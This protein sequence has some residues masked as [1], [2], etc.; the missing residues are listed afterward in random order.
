MHDRSLPE[1]PHLPP[2]ETVVTAAATRDLGSD[3]GSRFYE[4]A[5]GYAQS[6]WKQ[7]LPARSLLLLNRAMG[8]DLREGEPVLET[9][10]LPYAAVAW[11]LVERR[12]DQFIG[13]PRR[14][15][16]H[17]A[18]RMVAPRKEL[19]VWRAWACWHLSRLTLPEMPADDRQIAEEGIVEPSIGTIREGLLQHGLRGEADLWDSVANTV[20]SR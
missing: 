5:L 16:Q 7:G 14:H 1:C 4:A 2:A 6:L 13:N 3:R 18:T 10:P 20:L 12:P 8:C 11:I 9:W 15:W 19:R 17:L